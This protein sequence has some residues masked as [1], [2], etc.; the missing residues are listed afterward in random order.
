ML[1]NIVDIANELE[2]SAKQNQ[3]I[4]YLSLYTKLESIIEE[5]GAL[6]FET[7]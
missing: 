5:L 1:A 4:N 3:K 7:P 2:V 6:S